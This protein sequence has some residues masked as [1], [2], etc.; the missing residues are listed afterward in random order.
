MLE[1]NLKLTAGDIRPAGQ[2]CSA[3]S[4]KCIGRFSCFQHLGSASID[5][6]SVDLYGDNCCCMKERRRMYECLGGG[7]LTI[8]MSTLLSPIHYSIMSVCGLRGELSPDHCDKY[9]SPHNSAD[10][11]FVP[12]CRSCYISATSFSPSPTKAD[13]LPHI[14]ESE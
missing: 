13:D 8:A 7:A 1:H 4:R 6:Y 5:G 11:R 12:L 14:K 2:T 3:D 9:F 10:L